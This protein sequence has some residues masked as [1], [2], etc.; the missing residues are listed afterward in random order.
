MHELALAENILKISEVEARKHQ[1]ASITKIKLRVGEFT[2]VVREALEFSFQV[3]KQ[4]TLAE[5]AELEI[6]CIPLETRCPQCGRTATSP[7]QDVCL[8]CPTCGNAVEILSGRDLQVEY[9]C[10]E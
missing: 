4:G 10:L 7:L 5:N 9:V 1:A 8:I 2:G 6:E 3:L